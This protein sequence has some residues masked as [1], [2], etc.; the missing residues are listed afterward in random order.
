MSG[1]LPYMS[2]SVIMRIERALGTVRSRRGNT[3]TAKTDKESDINLHLGKRV[4]NRRRLLGL[5]QQQVA[6]K[7]S[8]RFQQIQK[9]ECGASRISAARLWELAHALQV[10]VGYFFEG[11]P[12]S[13]P[14]IPLDIVDEGESLPQSKPEDIHPCHCHPAM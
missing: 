1:L 14:G 7:C 4:R 3:V 13:N 5:T 8:V 2:I 11:L 10:P 9:Y 6:E 12:G